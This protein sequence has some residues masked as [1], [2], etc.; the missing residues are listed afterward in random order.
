MKEKEV[1]LLSH[2]EVMRNEVFLTGQTYRDARKLGD[3]SW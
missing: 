3:T 1:D 2:A